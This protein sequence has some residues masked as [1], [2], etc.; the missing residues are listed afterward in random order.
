[1]SLK[2]T[3]AKKETEE[4]KAIE[5]AYRDAVGNMVGLMIRTEAKITLINDTLRLSLLPKERDQLN[6]YKNKLTKS[7]D[8]VKM[9]KT[10][11]EKHKEDVTVKGTFFDYFT[12]KEVDWKEEI[13]DREKYLFLVNNVVNS[14]R[15]NAIKRGTQSPRQSRTSNR[16]PSRTPSP[17]PSHTT[18]TPS[19]TPSPTPSH[20][21]LTPSRT[22]SPRPSRTPSRTPSPR[23]SRT[24]NGTSIGGKGTRKTFMKSRKRKQTRTK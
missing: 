20:T 6:S 11:I 2:F 5:N 17:T 4:K 14:I 8:E 7:I 24:V 16:T 18:L 22:P 13:D 19:R 23:P 1:M 21:T 12:A 15:K 10:E 3:Y 9:M